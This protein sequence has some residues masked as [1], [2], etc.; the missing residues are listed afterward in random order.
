MIAPRLDCFSLHPNTP[1]LVASTPEREWMDRTSEHFAYRCTPLAIANAT[2]WELLNPVGFSATWTGR[3]GKHD[4]ILRPHV[5]GDPLAQTGF[6]FGHG[7][8]SFHPGYLFRTDAGWMTWV[9]GSPNR[10]KDGIHPLDGLVETSWLPFTF[11]MNWKFTRPCTVHFE[12]DEPFCFITMSPS[13]TIE[14]VQPN[15]MPLEDEPQLHREYRIWASE[16]SKFSSAMDLGDQLAIEQKWQ[17]NYLI[18]RSPSGNSVAGPDHRVK[19]GLN[20]PSFGCPVKHEP[21]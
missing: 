6:F 4:I 21:E 11:T 18:G 17:K 20:E 3:N 2:G 15:I 5:A 8:L 13:V 1:R 12:K 19:R 7:I 14:G 9:R 16:R 10:F